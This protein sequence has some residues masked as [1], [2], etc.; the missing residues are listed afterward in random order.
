MRKNKEEK[1]E[2]SAR[3]GQRKRLSEFAH[4]CVHA[5]HLFILK[6]DRPRLFVTCSQLRNPSDLREI[7]WV[8]TCQIPLIALSFSFPLLSTSLLFIKEKRILIY[9][10]CKMFEILL[11]FR[12]L[13][14]FYV[15]DF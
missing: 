3:G 13:E 9:I 15:S 10:L 4:V 5:L 7:M 8:T 2:A 12:A 11:T 6:I 14:V 1:R